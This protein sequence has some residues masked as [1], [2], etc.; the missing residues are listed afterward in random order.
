MTSRDLTH[1]V[2][3]AVNISSGQDGIQTM[4]SLTKTIRTLVDTGLWGEVSDS[5]FNSV[6]KRVQ[7]IV[8]VVVA[9]PTAVADTG[10]RPWVNSRRVEIDPYY[11]HRYRSLLSTKGMPQSVLVELESSVEQILDF[12]YD[13]MVVGHWDRRGLVMGNVQSGK[14]QH[15]VGLITKAADAGYR[16]IIVIA[17]LHN[18]LR[19]QTQQRVDEGFNGLHWSG[20]A[21]SQRKPVGVGLIDGT[22][23][24]SPFTATN[25]D[26]NTA[27][28]KSVGIPLRNLSEPAVFVIKKNASTLNNLLTWL[29]DNNLNTDGKISEPLLLIDDEADNASI[30][31]KAGS[32]SRSR[33]NSQIRE[34]LNLFE[35]SVYIGYTATPFANIFIDPDSEDEMVNED[36]FP[37]SFIVDLEPP[38]NGKKL[39]CLRCR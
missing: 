34:L 10:G 38:S 13:P 21:G 18:N 20:A 8:Q 26:F 12:A 5:E 2:A 37:R 6:V 22:R 11:W 15:Y 4:T 35:R 29:R 14:T 32:S 19:N 33:I 17:G 27:I 3:T 39:I 9:A 16:V 31:I 24:P 28:A 1:L 36:L 25:R 7:T 30:D 23:R